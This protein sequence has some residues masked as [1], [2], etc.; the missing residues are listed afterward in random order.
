[1]GNPFI[2]A[3]FNFMGGCGCY[4][5]PYG[6]YRGGYS[7]YT[8]GYAGVFGFPRAPFFPNSYDYR[9]YCGNMAYSAY[10]ATAYDPRAYRLGEY[11]DYN[12]NMMNMRLYPENTRMYNF[13]GKTHFVFNPDAGYSDI[14]RPNFAQNIYEMR[15]QV[16][17]AGI[18]C[19]LNLFE[20]RVNQQYQ[21]LD[22]FELYAKKLEECGDADKAKEVRGK[23]KELKELLEN[24]EKQMKEASQGFDMKKILHATDAVL[25]SL[26]EEFY[27]DCGWAKEQINELIEEADAY[28]EKL[29]DKEAGD[30]DEK[31][32]KT[33][34][35]E[36]DDNTTKTTKN[37]EKLDKDNFPEVKISTDT[38]SGETKKATS[39]NGNTEITKF[40]NSDDEIV[41]T[42]EIT[43]DSKGRLLK[44]V[45]KD[46]NGKVVKEINYEKGNVKSSYEVTENGKIEITYDKKGK[47]STIVESNTEDKE[48][49]V[50]KVEKKGYKKTIT[51]PDSTK[52]TIE[53]D[54][55]G[56]PKKKTTANSVEEYKYSDG[57]K[58]ETKKYDATGKTLVS[59]I[60]YEYENDEKMPVSATELN[61]SGAEIATY[62]FEYDDEGRLITETKTVNGQETVTEYEYDEFG[63]AVKVEEE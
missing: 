28:D 18:K 58:S 19:H 10:S 62:E 48:V 29:K 53:Y 57:K 42:V 15:K 5:M 2:N 34:K 8:G 52:T 6:G 45:E 38:K 41:R 46:E 27:S 33:E 25:K 24:Y 31:T 11:Y 54:E 26:N 39:T 12:Y 13:G 59:T 55:K 22:R 14:P 37:I 7:G 63:R 56:L 50:T 32:T 49:C 44:E 40:K 9:D 30:D 1:M 61:A 16:L 51:N 36:K 4:P 60:S 47:V 23:I 17:D 21:L 43:K 35:T 20:Q 3:M